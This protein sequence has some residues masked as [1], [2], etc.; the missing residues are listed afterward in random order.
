[1][2]YLRSY[3]EGRAQ[4]TTSIFVGEG[5][6]GYSAR[7]STH[8]CHRSIEQLCS[9]IHHKSLSPRAC[10]IFDNVMRICNYQYRRTTKVLI[11]ASTAIALREA[12]HQELLA[13]IAVRL[14]L[15]LSSVTK[16][17]VKAKTI[18]DIDLPP[19]DPSLYFPGLLKAIAD[20][21]DDPTS[22]LSPALRSYLRSVPLI[23]ASKFASSLA[24]I[25]RDISLHE[26]RALPTAACAILLMAFEGETGKA[27]PQHTDLIEKL[28]AR[29]GFSKSSIVERYRELGRVIDDWRGNLPWASQVSKSQRG[30]ALRDAN[31]RSLRDVITFQTQLKVKALAESPSSPEVPDL[32][33]GDDDFDDE[34]AFPLPEGLGGFSEL[35]WWDNLS[36]P[37]ITP[38]PASPRPTKRRRLSPSLSVLSDEFIPSKTTPTA[39]DEAY[40][41]N[42]GRPDAYVKRSKRS[43]GPRKEA[44]QKALASLLSFSP[45]G[46]RGACIS[47]PSASSM[48]DFRR[49]ILGEPELVTQHHVPGRLTF[50]SLQ[51]GGEEYIEDDELFGPGELDSLLQQI[52]D[53]TVTAP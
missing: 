29:I 32:F 39:V 17:F 15:K 53:E 42:K 8:N 4:V 18:L 21:L 30:V 50:L 7:V 35:E 46:E 48:P 1:M 2:R 5:T 40:F 51:R 11:G 23:K 45:A 14:S 26:N 38:P 16:M 9:S 10:N 28:G 3:D 47:T 41:P 34:P 19:N 36:D 37:S 6:K 31:A 24:A 44:M 22:G 43:G 49:A 20:L 13:E 12:G 52:P 27:M 33:F 25:P